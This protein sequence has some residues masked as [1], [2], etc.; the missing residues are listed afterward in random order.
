MKVVSFF[1]SSR[2]LL[3]FHA[4]F[5][6][7]SLFTVHNSTNMAAIP[8][9]LTIWIVL[10]STSCRSTCRSNMILILSNATFPVGS[11]LVEFL[12]LMCYAMLPIPEAD[13]TVLAPLTLT[14]ALKA[15]D[16]CCIEIHELD[17]KTSDI[18]CVYV[19]WMITFITYSYYDD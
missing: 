8:S 17:M 4:A 6:T 2:F 19:S 15:A 16:Y 14:W 3:Y 5:C 12:I 13:K 9:H 11:T 10:V 1:C 7:C 18:D